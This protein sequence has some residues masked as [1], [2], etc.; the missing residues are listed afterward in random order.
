MITLTNDSGRTVVL[1][2]DHIVS[3]VEAGTSAQ[4][5]GIKAYVRTVDN[6]LFEVHESVAQIKLMIQESQ[7]GAA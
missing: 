2:I 1:N 6:R 4:W 7:H 3:I 5:H